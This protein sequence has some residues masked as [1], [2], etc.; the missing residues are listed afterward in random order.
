MRYPAANLG[1]FLQRLAIETL[2][3]ETL[4]A[5]HAA[6]IVP[7]LSWV[8]LDASRLSCV[9]VRVPMLDGHHI[10]GFQ[11]GGGGKSE[12][13]GLDGAF[14]QR[15]PDVDDTIPTLQELIGFV[16]MVMPHAL[17]YR[18]LRLIDVSEL[19]G[20]AV[21][22]GSGAANGVIKEVDS[23][24]AGDVVQQQLLDLWVVVLLDGLVLDE[25]YLRRRR[26]GLD[27]LEGVAVEGGLRLATPDVVDAHLLGLVAV[28]AGGLPVGRPV[29]QVVRRGAVSGGGVEVERGGDVA[30]RDSVRESNAREGLCGGLGGCL[31]HWGW[32]ELKGFKAF[33]SFL[34]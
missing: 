14:I 25:V 30:A 19:H 20:G 5:S 17:R 3:K 34:C 28:V 31:R 21:G 13:E 10:I 2:E 15:S 23:V 6:Q 33:K 26:D 12:G 29:Y 1:A 18:L 32:G 9:S 22:V 8:V 16:G 27:D 4:I 24:A 7:F 11:S